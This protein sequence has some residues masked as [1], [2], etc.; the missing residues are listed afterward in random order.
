M[1]QAPLG[2]QFGAH[3]I[4]AQHARF[5]I[6]AP[7]VDALGLEL[8]GRASLPMRQVAGGWFE[9]QAAC[10]SGARYRYVL[11]DGSPVPDPASR[12]QDGDVHDR[13]IVVDPTSY[14]WRVPEW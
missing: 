13:S 12:A 9:L 11:P 7:D 3:P 1:S 4:D 5:R 14:V 8:D 6:W 10:A 2:W